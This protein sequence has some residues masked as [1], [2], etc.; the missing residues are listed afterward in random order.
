MIDRERII[1]QKIMEYAT[2]ALEYIGECSFDD[3]MSGKKTIS[4][5]AFTVG[6]IGKLTSNISEMTRQAH[7]N[8]PWLVLAIH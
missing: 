4:A 3:F 1:L 2:D 8:I 6:Q 5:Y 7:E